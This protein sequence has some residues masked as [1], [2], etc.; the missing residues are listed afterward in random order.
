MAPAIMQQVRDFALQFAR[1]M[2]AEDFAAAYELTGAIYRPKTSPALLAEEWRRMI[3][4][5]W[6]PMT[7]VEADPEPQDLL[8]DIEDIAA[9]LLEDQPIDV[10]YVYVSLAGDKYPYS[11]ALYIL[12]TLEGGALRAG[13]VYFGRP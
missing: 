4:S 8:T 10:I 12:V 3:P 5:D 7:H 6:G 13:D 2:I 11:E 9:I 1:A